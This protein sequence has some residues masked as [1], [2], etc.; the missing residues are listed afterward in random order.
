MPTELEELV[1]FISHGNTEVRQLAVENLVPYSLSQP[2]I[3]KTNE[4]L[5]IK[6]LKLLVRD[7]KQIAKDAITILINLSTDR[8]ILEDLASD[9]EFITS[10]LGRLTNPAEPNANLLSMLL[11]NLAK[12][13]DLKYILTLERPAPEELG[14]NNKAIDQLLDLF[15]KGA[16]G[17]YNKAAD[18]DYLSY[19]FADI[20]KHAEGR[21]Y[22]LTKQDYDSVVPL[23]KLTVFTEHKSDIRRK[24]VASTIKNV[25]FEIDSHPSFLAEDEINILPY[26]LLPITG[27]EEYDEEDTMAMLP[28]L[29]LL[30]PDK[31]RDSDPSIIQTHVETLMLLTTSRQGR[32]VLREIKVYPIIR[33]THLKVEH[34]GL[35]EVC[36]RFVQVLMRDEE[37]EEKVDEGMRALSRTSMSKTQGHGGPGSWA[38]QDEEE[39]DDDDTIEEV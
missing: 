15:V 39:D 14:S 22:F 33:E 31:Q 20:A 16:E 26:L 36:E 37:G 29:Q 18:Y 9:K 4:L 35:R 38:H 27:N 1:D 21:Q 5:P 3:F 8:E 30:P 2:S 28:D 7:Y 24:G 25:A 23:T 12:W 32:D 6:D 17:A 34:D 19:L 10:M 11:A 13:D